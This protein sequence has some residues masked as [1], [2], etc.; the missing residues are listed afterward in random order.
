MGDARSTTIRQL[1][2]QKAL[3]TGASRGIGRHLALT[4]GAAGAFVAL[5]ARDLEV[6][7]SARREVEDLGVTAIAGSLDVAWSESIDAYVAHAVDRL[8]G[9][10]MGINNAG[11]LTPGSL[12]E[13]GD[14]PWV[15]ALDTNVLGTV[16]MT[17]AAGR[18]PSEPREGHQHRVELR[19]Q[20]SLPARCVLRVQGR[21]RFLHPFDGG[22][23]G[24]PRRPG[25][26]HRP[27]LHRHDLNEQIRQDD[28]LSERV[29]RSVP[30]RRFGTVDDV[31]RLLL[32]LCDPRSIFITGSVFTVDG[33][34]TAR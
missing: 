20:G 9:L 3:I 8:G 10:D 6:L 34:E 24:Q 15:Q 33:G 11:V 19:V 27:P 2:G 29:R 12:L 13:D 5:G 25:E 23:V 1:E 22:R 30:A 28:V 32:P 7:E 21:D 4:L 16:R 18:H 31:A 14:A 17:R 26:C